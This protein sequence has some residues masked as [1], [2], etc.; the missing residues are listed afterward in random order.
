[1]FEERRPDVTRREE[2]VLWS[3]PD[4]DGDVVGVERDL[5]TEEIGW[6]LFQVRKEIREMV[7]KTST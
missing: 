3:H 7:G 1:M 5:E 2:E 4:G 6:N